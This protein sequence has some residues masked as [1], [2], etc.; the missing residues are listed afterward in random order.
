[1]RKGSS[2]IYF[3]FLHKEAFVTHTYHRLLSFCN[4]YREPKRLATNG[5]IDGLA[6]ELRKTANARINESDD[7]VT[8]SEYSYR[9]AP[10]KKH[11]RL[12]CTKLSAAV[13]RTLAADFSAARKTLGVSQ[14]SAKHVGTVP[15]CCF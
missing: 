5:D 8:V 12:H 7:I 1:M 14:I 2:T 13:P 3:K 11:C 15:L 9:Y 6:A 10:Q 4:A